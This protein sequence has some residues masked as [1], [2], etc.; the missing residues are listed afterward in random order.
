MDSIADSS[1]GPV[2]YCDGDDNV[3]SDRYPDEHRNHQTDNCR[4][5]TDCSHRIL[6]G[7]SSYNSNICRIKQLLKNTGKRKRQ[8]KSKHF[9]LERT[10]QHINLIVLFSPRFIHSFL[11]YR[12]TNRITPNTIRIP[13]Q[14]IMIAKE[15]L[16]TT[17]AAACS[18][19]FVSVWS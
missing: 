2:S 18:S 12:Y 9:S 7:K 10:A 11:I 6:A 3:R 19:L 1:G 15:K 14:V 5:G 17:G 4:V 13:R 8:S 16:M